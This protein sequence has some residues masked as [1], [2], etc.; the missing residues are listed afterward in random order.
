MALVLKLLLR[1]NK[2]QKQ[3][4]KINNLLLN[5]PLFSLAKRK[6]VSSWTR[7]KFAQSVGYTDV[8]DYRPVQYVLLVTFI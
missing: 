3:T 1:R 4:N 7:R 5:V 6:G 8:P 2:K